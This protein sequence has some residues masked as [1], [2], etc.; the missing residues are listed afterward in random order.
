MGNTGSSE[1]AETS[2]ISKAKLLLSDGDVTE[3]FSVLKKATEKGDV[4]ACYHCGFMMIQGIGCETDLKGGLELIEKGMKLQESSDIS[5][6]SDESDTE[7]FQPQAVFLSSLFF[8]LM[9][10][11]LCFTH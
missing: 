7:L 1:K 6:K 9:N 8:I 11:F 5:C 4:M 10:L 2:P 3:A